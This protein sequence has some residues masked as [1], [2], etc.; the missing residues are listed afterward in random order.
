MQNDLEYGKLS[1]MCGINGYFS[2]N[3]KKSRL[4]RQKCGEGN[5]PII[6]KGGGERIQLLVRIYSPD[7]FS[8]LIFAFN[9]SSSCSMSPTIIVINQD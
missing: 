2:W 7:T 6:S 9:Y 8:M 5:S 1:E 3:R 4:R